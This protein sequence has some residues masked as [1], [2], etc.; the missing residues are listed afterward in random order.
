MFARGGARGG[1]A[2]G[3]K[4]R[5]HTEITVALLFFVLISSP[6]FDQVDRLFIAFLYSQSVRVQSL[7]KR[8]LNVEPVDDAFLSAHA[9]KSGLAV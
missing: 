1:R 2:F 7:W 3:A 9:T 8:S 6:D 4:Q 5:A